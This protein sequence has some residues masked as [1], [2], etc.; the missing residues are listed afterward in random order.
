MCEEALDGISV[1]AQSIVPALSMQSICRCYFYEG[2]LN[3][4]KQ[5]LVLSMKCIFSIF[6]PNRGDIFFDTGILENSPR[7]LDDTLFKKL[8]SKKQARSYLRSLI[9]ARS[10]RKLNLERQILNYAD[11]NEVSKVFIFSEYHWEMWI[12]SDGVWKNSSTE[13]TRI[14]KELEVI[15]KRGFRHSK[16]IND[17]L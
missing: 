10:R 12:M 1:G 3:Y 11:N 5:L 6:V 14:L 9:P 2:D 7:D 16:Y 15:S 17:N 8:N 4:S 13:L